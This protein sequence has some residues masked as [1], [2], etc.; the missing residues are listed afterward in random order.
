MCEY[1]GYMSALPGQWFLSISESVSLAKI[2]SSCH[3]KCE[4]WAKADSPY[5]TSVSYKS[6]AQLR[7]MI[8]VGII[9]DYGKTDPWYPWAAEHI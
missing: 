4:N 5:K 2:Y 8:F 3:K 7:K 9:A 1:G 6:V